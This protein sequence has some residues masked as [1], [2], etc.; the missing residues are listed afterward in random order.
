MKV[1][2]F[3]DLWSFSNTVS[4]NTDEALS[5]LEVDEF[6]QQGLDNYVSFIGYRNDVGDLIPISDLGV[7]LSNLEGPSL[8]K[9]N[10]EIHRN[11]SLGKGVC[12]II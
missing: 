8:C 6:E 2:T 10:T 11:M 7:S 1:V 9:K 5:I 3:G 12:I 4:K